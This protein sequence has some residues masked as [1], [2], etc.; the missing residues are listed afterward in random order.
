MIESRSTSKL[1][2][3]SLSAD[4]L[5]KKVKVLFPVQDEDAS[6]CSFDVNSYKKNFKKCH[7][8]LKNMKMGETHL[9]GFVALK[10]L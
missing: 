4:N 1:P 3:K 7:S 5:K 6:T 9:I 10:R 2:T 8:A